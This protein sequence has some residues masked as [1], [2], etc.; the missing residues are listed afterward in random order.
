M[1]SQSNTL[2]II[3]SNH[4]RLSWTNDKALY[5]SDSILV[6]NGILQKY[7]KRKTDHTSWLSSVRKR[8]STYGHLLY[9]RTF[10]SPTRSKY[11]N[12][13]WTTRLR[14]HTIQNESSMIH[15][16][17][18][19]AYSPRLQTTN[20]VPSRNNNRTGVT[21]VNKRIHHQRIPAIFI[22]V[23]LCLFVSRYSQNIKFSRLYSHFWIFPRV[24]RYCCCCCSR[25]AR[26]ATPCSSCL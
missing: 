16:L 8:I 9:V 2:T 12:T 11:F 10:I 24:L 21:I 19:T 25:A 15:C 26:S 22:I 1:P 17:P 18:S 14:M 7:G 13:T 4:W 23:N 3:P 6:A 20:L 5:H